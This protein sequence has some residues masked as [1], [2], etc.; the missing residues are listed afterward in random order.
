MNRSRRAIFRFV[1]FLAT[2][3]LVAGHGGCGVDDGVVQTLSL[4]ARIVRVWT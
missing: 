4:V 3:G 1:T 2:G